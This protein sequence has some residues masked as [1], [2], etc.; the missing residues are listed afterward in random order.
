MRRTRKNPH[1]NTKVE[2]NIALFRLRYDG[3]GHSYSELG[4]IFGITT[5]RVGNILDYMHTMISADIDEGFLSEYDLYRKE[6]ILSWRRTYGKL[7]YI[8]EE[9]K[10]RREFAQHIR[11]AEEKAID[12]L[13]R[14]KFAMFGYWA[15]IWV[16]LNKIEG[17]KRPNPFK[18]F[19]DLAR[20]ES[21]D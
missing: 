9:N 19:V 14:Y 7:L 12:S 18:P 4:R 6:K 20:K 2:R 16:H 15:G 10:N 5:S 8:L 17:N 1:S 13:S 11:E 3:E 21:E